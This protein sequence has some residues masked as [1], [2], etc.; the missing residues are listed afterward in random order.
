MFNCIR[1]IHRLKGLKKFEN[2]NS[3]NDSSQ[4]PAMK[5]S[6]RSKNLPFTALLLLASSLVLFAVGCKTLST[7]QARASQ[8]IGS[9]VPVGTSREDAIKI[10]E[11]HGFTYNPAAASSSES[12]GDAVFEKKGRVHYWVARFHLEKD[13]IMTAPAVNIFLTSF[14]ET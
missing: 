8:T 7:D 6:T 12:P 9:W 13:K 5:Q 4:K 1:N 2:S 3:I 11:Q 10:M 14:I